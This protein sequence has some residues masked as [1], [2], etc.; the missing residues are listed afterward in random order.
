M[1]NL[2]LRKGSKESY[3]FGLLVSK[4]DPTTNIVG[5][6]S[7]NREERHKI[8]GGLAVLKQMNV[9][10]TVGLDGYMVNPSYWVDNKYS[11]HLKL[12]WLELTN[13]NY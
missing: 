3:V 13:K 12:K 7:S 8:N 9:V 6:T 4:I 10:S 2:K 5:V 11:N 1:P